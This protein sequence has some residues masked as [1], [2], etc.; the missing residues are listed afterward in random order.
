MR[1]IKYLLL[2]ILLSLFATSVFVAT[3]RGNFDTS[4]SIVVP[5]PKDVVFN[6]LNDL[7]NWE[8][9]YGERGA[10]RTYSNVTTGKGAMM[11]WETSLSDGSVQNI[12]T[13]GTDSIV[14]NVV[15]DDNLSKAYWVLKD[16]AGGTKIMFRVKGKMGF[17]PKVYATL[18]GGPE[19]IMGTEYAA[20]LDKF[21]GSIVSEISK[22]KIRIDGLVHKPAT[23]YIGQTITSTIPNTPKNINILTSKMIH[24]FTK[25]KLQMYG[26]PFVLYDYFDTNKNLAKFSVCIPVREEIYIAP[27]SDIVSG[28]TEAYLAVKTTLFGDYSHLKEAWDKSFG[29]IK[30]NKHTESDQG[31]YIEIYSVGKREIKRPSQWRTEIYIPVVDKVAPPP[32]ALVSVPRKPQPDPER[33]QTV[34]EAEISIP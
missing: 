12:S 4:Q 29:Y 26:K 32:P 23:Y 28:R 33:E 6:Y 27:E 16:T 13:A 30:N 21:K 1:I 22:Y 7:S 18:Q 2:I 11:K 24:F 14:Q 9:W 3:Q 20:D 34:P 31:N 10:E 8:L 5:L 17:M 15:T 25:N 19:K